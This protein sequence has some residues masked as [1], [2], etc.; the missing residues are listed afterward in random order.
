MRPR[1]EDESIE[2]YR[3]ECYRQKLI[4][5]VKSVGVNLSALYSETKEYNRQQLRSDMQCAKG[6]HPKAKK[7]RKHVHR[8]DRIG[9]DGQPVK[10]KSRE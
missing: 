10:D 4:V 3:A 2:E 7:W 5:K 9:L 6:T 8:P 1:R